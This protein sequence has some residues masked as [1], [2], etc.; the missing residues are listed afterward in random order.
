M[1]GSFSAAMLLSA[2]A[3]GCGGSTATSSV[4]GTIGGK[5][6]SAVDVASGNVSLATVGS[7]VGAIIEMSSVAGVCSDITQRVS[8]KNVTLL[9]I[10]LANASATSATPP[11]EPG[12]FT[13][14]NAPGPA[15][16]VLYE[17]RDAN[18]QIISAASTHAISG[19]VIVTNVDGKG[20]YAGTGDV[21]MYPSDHITFQF[22]ASNCP[23]IEM[24][25]SSA[26]TCM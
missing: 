12:T 14:T 2:L 8:P 3:C 20:G 1:R 7:N 22:S 16:K 24:M 21:I 26:E 19:S 25:L 5:T 17:E 13:V 6:F 9:S 11:T 15:A 23:A 10:I 4:T 18:C